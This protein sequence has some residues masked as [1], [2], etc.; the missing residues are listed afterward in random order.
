MFVV[1]SCVSCVG[2]LSV[3]LVYVVNMKVVIKVRMIIVSFGRLMVVNCF[4]VS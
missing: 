1:I 4:S 2:M 3:F